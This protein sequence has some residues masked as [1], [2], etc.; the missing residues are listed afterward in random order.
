MIQ[1][2]DNQRGWRQGRRRRSAAS[3][4]TLLEL[5]V[6]IAI[7]GIILTLLFAPLIQGFHLTARAR[8]IAAAQDSARNGLAQMRR[9]LSQAAYVFDDT[10]HPLVFPL[11][12]DQTASDF[13]LPSNVVNGT[14]A[15]FLPT[16]NYTK[17]DMIT[18]ARLAPTAGQLTDP[19]TGNVFDPTTGAVGSNLRFPLAPGTHLVRYFIGL[20]R[21]LDASGNPAY[22]SN[23]YE[24]WRTDD[25]FNPFILYRAEIDLSDTANLANYFDTSKKDWFTNPT[26]SYG[27]F[28]D[29]AFFYNTAIKG[30]N[31]Q[32]LAANW[33][34]VAQPVMNATRLDL[35]VVGRTPTGAVDPT[36]PFRSTV[37]FQPSAVTGDT[38][39]PGFLGNTATEL[40]GAVPTLYTAKYGAWTLPYRVTFNRGTT[41]GQA[42]VTGQLTVSVSMVPSGAGLAFQVTPLNVN[43]G[44]TPPYGSGSLAVAGLNAF[45]SAVSPTTG[46]IFVKTPN[47]AFAIDPDRGRIET[48]F[49]PLAGNLSNAGAPAISVGGTLRDMAAGDTTP[50]ANDLGELVP[51]VFRINTRDDFTIN[52]D[53]SAPKNQGFLNV[54]LFGYQDTNTA[55]AGNGNNYYLAGVGIPLGAQDNA[56]YTS[57]LNVFGQGSYPGVAIAPGTE[58]VLGPNSTLD[59]ANGGSDS[60]SYYRLPL[61]SQPSEASVDKTSVTP[62]TQYKDFTLPSPGYFFDYDIEPY[63]QLILSYAPATPYTIPGFPATPQGAATN[64]ELDVTYYWQNNFSRDQQGHALDADG[65]YA[66]DPTKTNQMGPIEADVV[67][68]DYSTRAILNVSVGARVYDAQS[69]VPQTVTLA[70]KIQIN[71]VGR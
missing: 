61:D 40:P 41:T 14:T 60:V 45:Y 35:L 29:P 70:D 59:A 48:G 3:A 26:A 19:T 4:F 10:G 52:A 30:P 67:K 42:G 36:N 47:L 51:T 69:R 25:D 18:A 1:N 53:P 54:H 21:N 55:K 43:G 66:T 38:A 31:G 13:R 39:T 28:D 5:I 20:Q 64:K 8:A 12:K 57:P 22:Y 63:D 33:A 44:T 34:K 23:P 27:G 37:N 62:P 49:P 17:I 58:R 11:Q 32:T 24:F 56:T 71:N 9:E 2:E 68:L 15:P 50:L 7:T 46:K 16:V 65:N 6:V